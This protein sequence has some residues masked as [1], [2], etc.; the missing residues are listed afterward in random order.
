MNE[1]VKL[2]IDNGVN[3]RTAYRI[4]RKDNKEQTKQKQYEVRKGKWA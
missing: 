3:K 4:A 1:R 2:L